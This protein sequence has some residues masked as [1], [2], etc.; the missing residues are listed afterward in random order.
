MQVV[1]EYLALQTKSILAFLFHHKNVLFFCS[2]GAIDIEILEIIQK[3]K[4]V[5]TL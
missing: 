1:N 4:L 2:S 3:S 5:L